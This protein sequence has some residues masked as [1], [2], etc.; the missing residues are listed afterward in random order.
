MALCLSIKAVFAFLYTAWGSSAY[1][2]AAARAPRAPGRLGYADMENEDC[3]CA[4]MASFPF[5]IITDNL[6]LASHHSLHVTRLHVPDNA[7]YPFMNLAECKTVK[8]LAIPHCNL[9]LSLHRVQ[10][11][12]ADDLALPNEVI[13]LLYR[14]WIIAG[15]G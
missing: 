5:L 10:L 14:P 1:V 6:V 11:F 13:L 2:T 9:P 15:Y 3:M 12:R 4:G 7:Y 8:K